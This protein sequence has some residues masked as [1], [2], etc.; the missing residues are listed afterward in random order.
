MAKRRVV[1]ASISSAAWRAERMWAGGGFSAHRCALAPEEEQGREKW[2][3]RARDRERKRKAD[4][5]RARV[6]DRISERDRARVHDR[7]SAFAHACMAPWVRMHLYE[8]Q[9]TREGASR[10][11]SERVTESRRQRGS[12]KTC[13]I[14]PAREKERERKRLRPRVR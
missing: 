5:D 7:K 9:R 3:K 13:K 4:K 6:N 14:V 11:A 1:L 8:E 2:G 10:Q 12:A